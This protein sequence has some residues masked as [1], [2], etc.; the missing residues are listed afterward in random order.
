[1]L[2]PSISM[3]AVSPARV[4]A[5]DVLQA[6]LAGAY[7]SDS[8][9]ERSFGLSFRDAGLAAQ[10]VFGCLRY[11]SQLDHLI[12]RYSGREAPALDDAVQI[13]LRSAIFQLR[14]LERVP[15][16][17]AVH[18]SVELAKSHKRA[19]SGFVNAV[20]RKVN[21]DPVIW[22]DVATELSCPGWLLDRWSSHFGVEAARGVAT[23]ALR[24]PHAYIRI[25]PGLAPDPGMEVEPTEVQ[26]AFRLLSARQSGFRL[27]DISSQAIIPLLEL[28]QGNTYLDLCAAPGNKTLQALETPLALTVACDISPKRIR[29]MPA[30]CPRVLLDATEPLPF[31]M[32]LDRIF[33]DAPCSGTGTLGRNTEIKWRLTEPDLVRFQTRQVGMLKQALELLAP[34]GKLVYATCSL[35][36]EESEQV[37]ARTLE[38]TTGID[39]TQEKWRVP[40]RDEGDGFYA[41]LLQRSRT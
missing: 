23:V 1:M 27:H 36:E 18:E 2:K 8:L 29:E 40:G 37:V 26:G 34:E 20:L 24:E 41:A 10:I 30:I 28:E 33:I 35:E 4:A 16:H 21:R 19:A 22:P 5:F 12:F 32:K 11:Q 17:A 3:R 7:A 15:P 6:V 39:C 25:Q 9:R 14:Y 31:G 13:V 38:Q